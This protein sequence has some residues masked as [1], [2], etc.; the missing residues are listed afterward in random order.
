MPLDQA[1]WVKW[2]VLGLRIA[3]S[4]VQVPPGS[5]SGRQPSTLKRE[6]NEYV[7]FGRNL[8]FTAR[9]IAKSHAMGTQGGTPVPCLDH[10]VRGLLGCQTREI[11]PI[12]WLILSDFSDFLKLILKSPHCYMTT[13]R[14]GF[15]VS[16]WMPDLCMQ[17]WLD[18]VRLRIEETPISGRFAVSVSFSVC[19]QSVV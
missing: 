7:P 14:H 10:L 2:Q 1:S 4:R 13:W 17:G 12:S 15:L 8:R 16:G 3:R 9:I 11:V 5:W 18:H 6:E 19:K